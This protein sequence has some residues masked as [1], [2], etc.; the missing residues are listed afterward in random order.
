MLSDESQDAS[1]LLGERLPDRISSCSH[2][3][4]LEKL[5]HDSGSVVVLSDD[6]GDASL[7][8]AIGS[9]TARAPTPRS[10]ISFTRLFGCKTS[11]HQDEL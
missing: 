8:A 2:R 9:Y 10:R 7:T 6:D 11:P 3:T 5:C 1:I 4:I